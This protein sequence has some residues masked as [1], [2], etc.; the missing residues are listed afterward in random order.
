MKRLQ[1]VI[2]VEHMQKEI[3]TYSDEEYSN[4]RKLIAF[5]TVNGLD[6]LLLLIIEEYLSKLTID[7]TVKRYLVNLI[8]NIMRDVPDD[9]EIWRTFTYLTASIVYE[10]EMKELYQLYISVLKLSTEY[11]ILK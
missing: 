9:L 6:L 5:A 4:I 1:Q 8:E 11:L 7:E 2:D 10:L 3:R